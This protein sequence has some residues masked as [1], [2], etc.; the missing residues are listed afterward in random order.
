MAFDGVFIYHLINEFNTELKQARI[1]KINQT[2]K[3]LFSFQLYFNKKRMFLNINLNSHL[4]SAFLT[5]TKSTSSL[6]SQFLMTLRKH[7]EGGII[8]NISQHH[9]DRVI[10]FDI[11]TYDFLEGPV[12]RQLIFEAMGKHANL[13]LISDNIILDCFKKS[14]SLTSRQLMPKATFEYF[15][16]SKLS[17]L[18]YTYDAH[19][20]YKEITE[21]YEGVST[22]LA[23]YLVSEK[24]MSLKN[25]EVV[26]TLELDS[27]KFYFIDI[28]NSSNKKYFNSLSELLSNRG[29]KKVTSNL[30]LEKFIDDKL[31]KAIKKKVTLESQKLT[32]EKNLVYKDYGDYIYQSNLDLN[33]KS[34]TLDDILLDSNLTLNQNA[35]KFYKLYQKAKRTITHMGDFLIEIEDKITWYE[36]IIKSFSYLNSDDYNDLEQE[37]ILEG[38]SKKKQVHHSKKKSKPNILQIEIPEGIIYIGKSSTQNAYLVS[39][40][41]HSNDYWFHIKDG[42]GSHV[43]YRGDTLNENV[44]RVASMLAAHFSSYSDSSSIPVDYTQV[45]NLKKIPGKPGYQLNYKNHK[46]IY[47]D[48]SKEMIDSLISKQ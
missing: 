45:R 23:K 12:T 7:L 41:A 9:T 13:Y 47:I 28:F 35:Q 25:L 48:I 17:F 19:L 8:N 34:A 22:L 36:D 24:V 3:E 40:I 21:K 46:T 15:P 10:I 37:L 4:C 29:I 14:F 30:K 2:D 27:Q 39:E 38:Y 33:L 32:A 11:T 16:S 5:S 1:E 44:I 42:G 31:K 20:S 26:P 18:D 6:S 43:I